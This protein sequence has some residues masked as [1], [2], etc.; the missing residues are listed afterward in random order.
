MSEVHQRLP[1]SW[2]IEEGGHVRI[3]PNRRDDVPRS[4]GVDPSGR[5]DDDGG[6]RMTWLPAPFRFCLN[7]GVSYDPS[8]RSDLSKLSQLSTEGRSSATS[9]LS[10]SLVRSLR[11]DHELAPEARKLLS[12]TDNRQDASLQAGHFN[13]FVQIGL[14]R[15]ALSAALRAAAP[16]P[17]RSDDLVGA[18][19]DALSLPFADFAQDPEVKFAAR[20]QTERAF[21]SMLGYRLY[22]DLR[23]GWRVTM[24]NLEQSGLLRIERLSRSSLILGERPPG[25]CAL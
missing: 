11:S 16:D 9:L 23:R 8:M 1:E 14:L 25:T 22:Q 19:F 13:D 18:V 2:L 3:D 20:A 15:G 17:L 21:R 7:C 5:I 6:T 4:V 10:L 12:F 24:P